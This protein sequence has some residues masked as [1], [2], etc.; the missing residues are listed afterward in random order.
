MYL[1]VV[2]LWLSVAHGLR[3]APGHAQSRALARSRA[4]ASMQE[5]TEAADLTKKAIRRQIM[6]KDSYMRGGSP[7]EKEIHKDV[8]GKMSEM[9]AGELVE[10]MKESSF[11]ELTIGEGSRQI[12]FVLAKARGLGRGLGR[13]FA[14]Q[15]EG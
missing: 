3:V 2:L 14:G 15:G 13:G 7:F 5:T 8:S 4:S 11:R 1:L 10:K 9:F 6:T 12:T